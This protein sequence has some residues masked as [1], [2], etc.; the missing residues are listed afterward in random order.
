MGSTNAQEVYEYDV[1]DDQIGPVLLNRQSAALT[2]RFGT[3][4]D[5][6][7]VANIA[8]RTAYYALFGTGTAAKPCIVHRADAPAGLRVEFNDGTG[9]KPY[10]T[11]KLPIR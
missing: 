5:V 1:T 6:K 2:A 4:L 9:W 7:M 11:H 3:R 8:D 10:L